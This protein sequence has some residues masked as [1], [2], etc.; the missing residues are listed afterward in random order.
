MYRQLEL[1]QEYKQRLS[2][3][4]RTR[5]AHQLVNQAL[6]LITVGSNDQLLLGANTNCLIMSSFLFHIL[7]LLMR[8]Y[9]EGACSVLVMG[10]GPL[11][12]VPAEL[13]MQGTNGGCCEVLQLAASLYNSQLDQILNGPNQK[14][15]RGV[16]TSANTERAVY[17]ARLTTFE[18]SE[19]EKAVMFPTGSLG[20]G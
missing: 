1:F 14:I 20:I 15:G 5:Q 10:T 7:V 16:F 19:K 12:C 8:L 17:G 9:N 4:V 13:A 18:D 6:V 2:P 3:L 11:G